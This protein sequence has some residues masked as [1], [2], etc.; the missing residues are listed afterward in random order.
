[1]TYELAKKL[2][3][4]GF[5]FKEW[6]LEEHCGKSSELQW[7]NKDWEY[8]TLSELIEACGE[9]FGELSLCSCMPA[10]HNHA[11]IWDAKAKDEMIN[12]EHQDKWA[13]RGD[14][15]EEAVAKLWLALN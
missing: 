3:E 1:M 7:D 6:Y 14:T 8:P 13:G 2:K 11:C 12:G 15:P 5:T 4:A 9:E 10:P